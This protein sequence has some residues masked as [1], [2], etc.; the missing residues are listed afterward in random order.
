MKEKLYEALGQ[1][2]MVVLIMVAF[3]TIVAYGF[4]LVQIAKHDLTNTYYFLLFVS[5][6]TCAYY[7]FKFLIIQVSRELL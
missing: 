6:G 7:F 1:L 3:V 2:F 5:F 4:A